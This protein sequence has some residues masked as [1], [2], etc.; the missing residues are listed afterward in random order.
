MTIDNLA[1][2]VAATLP[3]ATGSTAPVHLVGHSLGGKVAMALALAKPE[4]VKRMVVADISPVVY[5]KHNPQWQEVVDICTAVHEMDLSSLKRRS[6]GH[7]LLTERG[8]VSWA[9]FFVMV[10]FETEGCFP[11]PKDRQAFVLQN[12]APTSEGGFTWRVNPGV[13]R[14]SL[15]NLAEFP[16]KCLRVLQCRLGRI[17]TDAPLPDLQTSVRHSLACPRCSF[18][19]KRAPTSSRSTNQKLSVYSLAVATPPSL[20]RATGCTPKRPLPS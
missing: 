8:I 4:L 12:L 6:D 16:R 13:I 19:V 3:V 18:L 17:L 5:D 7:A 15:S 9:S 2:D 14:S 10:P 11:Q 20:M 1:A